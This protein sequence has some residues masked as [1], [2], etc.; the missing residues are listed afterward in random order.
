MTGF[1]CPDT[2]KPKKKT[3]YAAIQREVDKFL[4]SLE[5]NHAVIDSA[6]PGIGRDHWLAYPEKKGEVY[7][8]VDPIIR[9][10]FKSGW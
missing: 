2:F 9:R 10:Y 1:G 8:I 6:V 7:S 3:S 5:A 4:G